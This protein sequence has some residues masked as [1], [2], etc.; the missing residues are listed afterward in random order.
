MWWSSD[1]I[2]ERVS[3]RLCYLKKKDFVAPF[4]EWG[5][6]PSGLQSHYEE[7][8][9]LPLSSQKFLILIWLI[10]E[11]WKVESTLEPPSGFE[12]GTSG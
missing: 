5:S 4:D 1:C 12:H 6:A 8:V 9:F 3:C 10:S 2:L 7:A 11:G